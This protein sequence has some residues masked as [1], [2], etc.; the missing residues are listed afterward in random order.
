MM[1]YLHLPI[2]DHHYFLT[3]SYMEVAKM[4]LFGT[5]VSHMSHSQS[6][7]VFSKQPKV[8]LT[9][10]LSFSRI[11]ESTTGYTFTPCVGSFTSPG[12]DTR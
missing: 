2:Y 11:S 3:M 8:G 1:V 9:Q 12:I 4:A 7:V 6:Q 5:G 10:E